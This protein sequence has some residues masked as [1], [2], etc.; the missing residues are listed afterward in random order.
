M[1]P[2]AQGRNAAFEVPP[3]PTAARRRDASSTKAASACA[4]AVAALFLAHAAHLNVV[5][6][7]AFISFRFARHLAGGHGLVWN[8]GEAPVEGYTNFLWVLISALVIKAGLDVVAVSQAI[9]VLAALATM[10]CAYRFA[11]RVLGQSRLAAL[12]P[13]LLLA[14][15][16]PFAAWAGSG[17]ETS[18]FGTWLLTGCYYFAL[19]V[20][21][22][23]DHHLVLCCVTL[24]FATLTRPEG[25]IGFSVVTALAVAFSLR[26]PRARIVRRLLAACVY[27]G[28]FLLYFWWRY[29]YFG[30]LLPNAYY[31]KT[32]GGFLQYLRGLKYTGLFAFHYL[33]PLAPV[34]FALGWERAPLQP[35][36]F[37]WRTTLE[38]ARRHVGLYLCVLVIAAYTLCIVCLG[39]DYMAMYRFF[40]PILLFFYL[41]AGAASSRLFRDIAGTRRKE[42]LAAGLIMAG[43]VTTAVQSTPL[44]SRLF[45]KPAF[46][47]GTYQGVQYERW[48]VERYRVIAEF[49]RQHPQPRGASV[50]VGPVGVIAFYT[51]LPVHGIFGITDTRIAHMK[52]D[53][54]GR[55]FPGHEKHDLPYVLSKTPTYVID[56]LALTPRPGSYPQHDAESN[57]VLRENY[58]PTSVWLEDP[59]NR[60]SGYFT[61]LELKGVER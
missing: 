11:R 40:V 60:E 17:M 52:V 55:G 20:R 30:F 27:V 39:G 25:L 38:H 6:E 49:F 5:V 16:G 12:I 29:D 45:R 2:V 59:A 61:F 34:A 42:A 3:G 50:A 31:A 46:M 22:S 43:V 8:V 14:V 13:C 41:V 33:L 57:R 32:G 9:G 24:L 21:G 47:H 1:S 28:P 18:L 48:H 35:D 36:P 37:H 58:R 4:V 19:W 53:G 26:A 10:G 54:L 44:E 51:G 56:S 7:D 23:R 15:S